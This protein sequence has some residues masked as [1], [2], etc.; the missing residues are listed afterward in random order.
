MT[1]EELLQELKTKL[2]RLQKLEEAFAGTSGS[3]GSKKKRKSMSA[4]A[5][6]AIGDAQRRRHAEARKNKKEG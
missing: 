3:T 2:E 4:E 6:K 1:T 5:R